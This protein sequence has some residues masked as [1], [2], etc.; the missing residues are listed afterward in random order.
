MLY[1]GCG[2]G[3]AFGAMVDLSAHDLGETEL[4]DRFRRFAAVEAV[5]S[6]PFYAR[7]AALCAQTPAAL[8]I[9]AL[10]TP[11]QP[12]VNLLFAAIHL[13]ILRGDPHP[14]RRFFPS[15]SPPLQ[16]SGAD[17]GLPAALADFL[18]GREAALSALVRARRVATNEPSRMAAL[19]L[20]L[21]VGLD[22]IG[23]ADAIAL[24]D[25]GT[26]AGLTLY[27]DQVLIDFGGGRRTGA[28]DAPLRLPVRLDPPTTPPPADLPPVIQR[29]GVDTHPMNA[30]DPDDADWLRAL[31][32]PEH[33]ARFARLEATLA[34]A[35]IA[36][37]RLVA[38]DAAS[39]IGE[40]ALAAPSEALVCVTHSMTLHQWPEPRR[41]L[42]HE[43]LKG[44]SMRRP[45]LRASL[46]HRPG[47]ATPT[48]EFS[49]YRRGA[50]T[51]RV[52]L[53][54]ADPHGAWIAMRR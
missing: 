41:R 30:A 36:P 17:D 38:A 42:F 23:G 7:L 37:P 51:M 21:S 22:N 52:T 32:W 27:P 45:V 29:I 54:D 31:I 2:G 33:A 53:A 8:R 24:I 34:L 19:T 4:P 25:A 40:L 48:V 11:D 47:D 28:D 49:I 1:L 5:S 43:Q 50:Q 9:A 46:E 44:V 15:V 20:A 16:G 18:D 12:P 35:R 6:S 3:V 10:R 14:L 13:L 39:V 26:S